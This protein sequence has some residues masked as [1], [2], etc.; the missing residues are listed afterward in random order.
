MQRFLNLFVWNGFLL[1]L[2]HSTSI[3]GNDIV[4]RDVGDVF[5]MVNTK[6][7]EEYKSHGSDKKCF[8]F[9]LNHDFSLPAAKRRTRVSRT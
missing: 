9:Y 2:L 7:D 1:R 8:T 5:L 3:F 6:I 4:Y